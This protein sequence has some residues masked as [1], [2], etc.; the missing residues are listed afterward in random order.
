M[1]LIITGDVLRPCYNSDNGEIGIIVSGGTPGYT[2]LWSN[3]ETTQNITGLVEGLYYVT[4]TDSLG[5]TGQQS[6]LVGEAEPI[7]ID[8]EINQTLRNIKAVPSGGVG[9][10]TYLWTTGSTNNEITGVEPGE[11]CVTVMSGEQSCRAVACTKILSQ[12]EID[13]FVFKCCAGKLG[14][15]Y[16]RELQTGQKEEAACDKNRLVLINGY[17]EDLCQNLQL[18]S[19][20]KTQVTELFDNLTNT[21]DNIEIVSAD[22]TALN[23]LISTGW[24]TLLAAMIDLTYAISN[25]G[26][27]ASAWERPICNTAN[28][29]AYFRMNAPCNLRKCV[30]F[31]IRALIN[32]DDS[33]TNIFTATI[34]CP[35][36]LTDCLTDEQIEDTTE[37]AVTL[38]GCCEEGNLF[39]DTLIK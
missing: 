13:I 1:S 21:Y 19:L 16:V 26:Y 17:I 33:P 37:K 24:A 15:K 6:F 29:Q 18:K 12:A 3:G 8:F 23:I 10:F 27:T 38:C 11:Y 34:G 31:T 2:Y 28:T 25:T 22:D 36:P 20:T 30:T 35:E 14:Y 7:T 9:L 5:E 32:G 4:V 39:D